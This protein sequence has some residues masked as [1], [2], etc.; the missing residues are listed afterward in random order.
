MLRKLCDSINGFTLGLMGLSVAREV[1][2][3]PASAFH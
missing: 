2:S 3:L 1:V